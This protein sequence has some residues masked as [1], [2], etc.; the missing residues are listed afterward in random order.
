VSA[1]GRAAS[2]S[3]QSGRSVCDCR[4]VVAHVRPIAA[5]HVVRGATTRAAQ[6]LRR[7]VHETIDG[8]RA[9]ARYRD[10]GPLI[11]LALAASLTRGPS[12]RRPRGRGSGSV[13]AS[14]DGGRSASARAS[15]SGNDVRDR[16]RERARGHRPVH[17]APR[18]VPEALHAR[19]FGV[20]ESLTAAA[21][22]V[23]SSSRRSSSNCSGSAAPCSHS[24][25]SPP[26]SPHSPDGVCTRSPAVRAHAAP[27]LHARPEPLPR[28]SQR[29]RVEWPRS[30]R[31]RTRRDRH[32][33]PAQRADQ[34]TRKPRMSAITG[35]GAVAD[36]PCSLPPLESALGGSERAWLPALPC[37]ARRG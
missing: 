17:A 3:R 2:R 22:A 4:S 32:F 14:P 36:A 15:G 6:T 35:I 25:S 33:R 12:A 24:G 26:R 21:F 30:G 7:I 37:A 27:A 1:S 8:F 10:A 13:G 9:L 29:L 20:K 23:G 11:G 18:L 19:V 31:S 34:L 5:R 16:P 28:R